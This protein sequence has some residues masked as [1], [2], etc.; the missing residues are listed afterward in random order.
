MIVIGAKGFA[1]EVLTVLYQQANQIEDIFFFDDV[2]KDLEDMLFGKFPIIKSTVAAKEILAQ[3]PYFVLGLGSPQLR[4]MMTKKF[5]SMG[6]HLQSVISPKAVIGSFGVQIEEGVSIMSG[7]VITSDIQIGKGVILNLNCTIGHD[8][9]IEDFV[10]C[11]PGVHISGNVKI[12]VNTVIGTG[13]VL[14]PKINVGNN[15]IIGAG[16]VVRNDIPDNSL[17]VGIPGKVIKRI[18]ENI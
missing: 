16:S 3:N 18:N 13:A 11:A 9:I 8:S 6:G 5:E 15:C 10:E 4:R 17:V 2:S 7:T 12:G 14:L 1:K